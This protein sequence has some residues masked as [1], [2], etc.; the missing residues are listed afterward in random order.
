MNG[1]RLDDLAARLF[2]AARQ[3]QP[4]D[5]THRR[6]ALALRRQREAPIPRPWPP[7]SVAVAVG[8][9]ALAAGTWLL[10]RERHAPVNITAET[11]RSASRSAPELGSAPAI[12]APRLS[13]PAESRPRPSAERPRLPPTL[14]DELDV[15]QRARSA[16]GSGDP[17]RALGELD[18]YDRVLQGRKLESEATLL[19]IEALSRTG[20]A[21][22]A[23]ALARRFIESNP[24]HPL[25][26]QA[27]RYAE[28]ASQ[29]P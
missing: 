19:R 29:A 5:T 27:R 16:L 13:P 11:P 8:V 12:E 14:A 23:A 18:R 6:I 25:V 10:L 15:L 4:P 17:A 3:D 2:D 28:G 26:D 20:R 22:Q 7:K 21:E 24:N 9:T 1:D